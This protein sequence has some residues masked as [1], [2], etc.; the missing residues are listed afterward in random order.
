MEI[1]IVYWGY[2]GIIVYRRLVFWHA[3]SG[4][5]GCAVLRRRSRKT[6]PVVE[7]APTIGVTSGEW[8]RKWKLL[9]YNRVYIRVM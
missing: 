4:F 5:Q 2:I 1:T 7:L 8:K 3:I 9:R 6:A